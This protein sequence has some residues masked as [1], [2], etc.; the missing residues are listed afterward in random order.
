MGTKPSRHGPDQAFVHAENEDG[1]ARAALEEQTGKHLG[2][3]LRKSEMVRK[4]GASSAALQR[5]L[6]ARKL[7]PGDGWAA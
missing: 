1:Y 7:K 6:Q 4:S 5:K 2:C 3:R